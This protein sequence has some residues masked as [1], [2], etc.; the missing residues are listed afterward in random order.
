MKKIFLL[1]F[2][3]HLIS[4]LLSVQYPRTQG[5]VSDYANILTSS[6]LNQLT[7]I[8]TELNQKTSVELAVVSVDNFQGLD[9]DSYAIGL[10]EAWAIGSKDDEGILI[11][12]SI[13]DREIKVEVGYG[14]E[15]YLTD[16]SAGQLLDDY[17]MPLLIQNEYGEGLFTAG[18]V[19]SNFVA[20]A[21][22][23]ELSGMPAV[24]SQAPVPT[25]TNIIFELFVL[26]VFIFLVIIT[27][28]RILIWLALFLRG[29]RGGGF[30]GGR[31]GS[32]GFGG[33]GGGRSGGGG[34]GRRF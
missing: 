18:V 1:L 29:G 31:G 17:V 23:V 2:L 20:H 8:I 25:G 30:G 34:A 10:F 14:S 19:F 27:R 15:G 33:F 22:G 12:L 24:V 6:Q 28:G 26:G 21:K 3:L 7:N 11:L 13:E 5:W 32:G 4:G 16:G 9:R